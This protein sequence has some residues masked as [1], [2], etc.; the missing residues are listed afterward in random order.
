MGQARKTDLLLSAPSRPQ[1]EARQ[2]DQARRVAA[3]EAARAVAAERERAA[4]LGSGGGSGGSIPGV[5]PPSVHVPSSVL[6]SVNEARRNAA[7]MADV[8]A[9]ARAREAAHA[10]REASSPVEGKSAYARAMEAL[11]DRGGAIPVPHL[12]GGIAGGGLGTA[13]YM[14]SPGG[15][16]ST[17]RQLSP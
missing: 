10:R 15:Q 7:E 16:R 1:I 2:L 8:R 6:E 3:E 17:R 11:P 14:Q 13:G 5:A 12:P 4:R 9:E